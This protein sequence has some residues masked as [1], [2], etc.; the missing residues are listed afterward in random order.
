MT[1]VH[2]PFTPYN[3]SNTC[4][5]SI[6]WGG[7]IVTKYRL[8]LVYTVFYLYSVLVIELMHA[9]IIVQPTLYITVLHT[10]HILVNYKYISL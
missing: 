5:I 3:T 9:S 1:V 6:P 8:H 7:G 4:I 2:P 10:S